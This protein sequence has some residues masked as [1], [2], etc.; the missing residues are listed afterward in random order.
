M[1]F[2]PGLEGLGERLLARKRGAAER[3]AETVWQAYLRRKKCAPRNP[4]SQNV[5]VRVLPVAQAGSALDGR[6]MFGR[7]SAWKSQMSRV[8]RET[9]YR[10]ISE[11]PVEMTCHGACCELQPCCT[12]VEHLLVVWGWGT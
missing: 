11:H 1:T 9:L 10:S 12:G 3:S 2:A 4:P 7:L 5:L 8:A 6:Q